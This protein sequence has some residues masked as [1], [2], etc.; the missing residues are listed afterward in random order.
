MARKKLSQN[1][2][3]K[4]Q[5]RSTPRVTHTKSGSGVAKTVPTGT[6]RN[7]IRNLGKYAH[8]PSKLPKMGMTVKAKRKSNKLKGY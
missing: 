4:D 2:R 6:H 1:V 5:V 8:P 3:I 7:R